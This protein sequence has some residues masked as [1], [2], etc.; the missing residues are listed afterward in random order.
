MKYLKN[1][2]L[3]ILSTIFTLLVIE[4]FLSKFLPQARN[5][6]W[7]TQDISGTYLNKKNR[8][9]K[10]EFIGKYE[11]IF[12]NYRF[13]EYHNRIYNDELYTKNMQKILVLGDSSIFGWLLSDQDT[14]VSKLQNRYKDYYFVNASAGGWSD[15]DMYNY[16]K[17]F[18]SSI[19]PKLILFFL[20]IDRTIRTNSIYYDSQNKLNF[21]KVEINNFKKFLNDKKLYSL[22]SENSHLFQ[23]I[24]RLYV[25]FSNDNYINFDKKN[26]KNKPNKIKKISKTELQK[27]LDINLKLFLSLVDLINHEANKCGSKIIYFDRGWH[28]KKDNSKIKNLTFEVLA[29]KESKNEINFIS[30]YEK[31][32]IIRKE[33]KKYLLEEG[34]PNILANEIKFQLISDELESYLN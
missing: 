27:K 33:P 6:S 25:N 24:K 18:C 1:F 22:I 8:V 34:H 21:K 14:F 7:R 29:K 12:V 4:L 11:K 23:I 20:E 15:V 26:Y 28:D 9:S 32:N 5:D 16:I 13:G 10:H 3:I 19:Q 30:L 17:K 2:S 31:M